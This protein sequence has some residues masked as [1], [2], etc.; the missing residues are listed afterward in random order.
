MSEEGVLEGLLSLTLTPQECTVPPDIAHALCH[1][2]SFCEA[3][4]VS[5]VTGQNQ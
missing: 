1:F 4:G 5:Y 2:P 3:E